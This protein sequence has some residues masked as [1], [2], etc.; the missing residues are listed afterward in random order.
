MLNDGRLNGEDNGS[1]ID[2][3]MKQ[4]VRDARQRHKKLGN[5]VAEWRDGKV[6]WIA[7]EDIEDAEPA[8]PTDPA[9]PAP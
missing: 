7:P 9:G 4:A 6:V 5:P 2:A 3:A 1:P 8:R